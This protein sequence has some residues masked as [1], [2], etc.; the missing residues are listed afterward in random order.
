MNPANTQAICDRLRHLRHERG[1]NQAKVAALVFTSQQ[2]YSRLETGRS[3]LTSDMIIRLAALY[4]VSTDYLLGLTDRR[5]PALRG[6]PAECPQA[7]KPLAG[8]VTYYDFCIRIEQMTEQDRRR[9]ADFARYLWY[10]EQMRWGGRKEA[11]QP[12]SPTTGEKAT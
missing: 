6:R 10:S 5:T 9:V 11:E 3:P 4:G 7:D 2:F 8:E 1:W 12:E